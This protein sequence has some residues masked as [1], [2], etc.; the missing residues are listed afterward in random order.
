MSERGSRATHPKET[1]PK[2]AYS[3]ADVTKLTGVG[4]SFIYDEIKAGR[5]H[6]RKAG[7]RTLIFNADLQAWLAQLPDQ[8]ARRLPSQ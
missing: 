6:I 7:R 5:L 4:R 8:H 2:L 3:I 1:S